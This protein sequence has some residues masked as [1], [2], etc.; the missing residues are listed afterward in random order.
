VPNANHG[1]DKQTR[2]VES[3]SAFIFR[4]RTRDTDTPDESFTYQ[5]A[6]VS[7]IA[8]LPIRSPAFFGEGMQFL[9]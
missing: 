8:P 7:H 4:F 2:N 6:H 9:L 3:S 5:I 1:S